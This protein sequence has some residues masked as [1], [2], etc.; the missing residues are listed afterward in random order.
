M[1][2][3]RKGILGKDE[4]SLRP[5]AIVASRPQRQGSGDER[6]DKNSRPALDATP[7][8]QGYGCLVR[9]VVK[10]QTKQRHDQ[11]TLDTGRPR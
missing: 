7:G 10:R 5:D 6:S 4:A 11:K 8:P 1:V 2:R 3:R 9:G